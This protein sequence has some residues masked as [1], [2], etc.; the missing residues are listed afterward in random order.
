[1]KKNYFLNAIIILTLIA[2]YE[3]AVSQTETKQVIICNGGVYG[4]PSDHVTLSTYDP[5]GQTTTVFGDIFT[6]SVQDIVIKENFAF[7]SAQDSIVKF[8]IDITE[9]K[10]TELKEVVLSP[11][12]NKL[13]I[14]R[15][16]FYTGD[17][18]VFSLKFKLNTECRAVVKVVDDK[19]EVIFNDKIKYFPGRLP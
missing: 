2:M 19:G 7:V 14:K 17:D 16:E 18:G 6:E 1:M 11:K 13:D 5:L 15:M 12:S 4:D 3:M 8:N 10:K 9:A